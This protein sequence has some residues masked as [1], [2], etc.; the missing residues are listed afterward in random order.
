MK[1]SMIAVLVL[2]I[3]AAAIY[4]VPPFLLPDAEW[5]GSDDQGSQM[6]GEIIGG[7][8]EPW[9]QPVM[10]QIIGDELSEGAEALL[11][12][13]QGAIG[14]AVLAFGFVVL[15]KRRK[16]SKSENFA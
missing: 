3:I 7:G 2:V 1:K 15:N 10:E 6:V 4:F 12:V 11:F 16:L 9:A 5:D 14:V 13:L 8:Y